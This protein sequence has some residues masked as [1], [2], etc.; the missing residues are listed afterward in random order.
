MSE[1]FFYAAHS[2]QSGRLSFYLHPDLSSPLVRDKCGY[3]DLTAKE[4]SY[5][6]H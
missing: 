6:P 3:G 1:L 2:Y 4:G 5:G